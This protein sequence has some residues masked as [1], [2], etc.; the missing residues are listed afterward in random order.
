MNASGQVAGGYQDSNNI[1][2]GFIY[3]N[4]TY[5][6]LTDPS[7]AGSTFAEAI[8]DSGPRCT[9]LRRM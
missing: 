6:T 8:N 3:I 4:G 7:A 2:H 9:L 1:E 5:T